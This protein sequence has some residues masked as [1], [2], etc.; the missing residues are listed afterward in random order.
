MVVMATTADIV[1]VLLLCVPFFCEIGEILT[2]RK[3]TIFFNGEVIGRV[4]LILVNKIISQ[5]FGEDL[6]KTNL[7]R[8]NKFKPVL[9]G[10]VI[11]YLISSEAKQ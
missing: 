11:V 9:I 10:E 8:L 2:N 6:A 7:V 3:P 5:R 1:V 4:D